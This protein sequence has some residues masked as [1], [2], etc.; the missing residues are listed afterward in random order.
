[1]KY[2]IGHVVASIAGIIFGALIGFI[3]GMASTVGKPYC[4]TKGN[5]GACL[6]MLILDSF[7]LLVLIAS[8]SG[9]KNHNYLVKAASLTGIITSVISFVI[10]LWGTFGGIRIH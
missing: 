7:P 2:T 10:C 8:F 9:I 4:F 5:Y 3:L 6:I 1:M